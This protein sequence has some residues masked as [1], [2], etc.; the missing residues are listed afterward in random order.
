M[1]ADDLSGAADASVHFAGRRQVR[2]TYPRGPLWDARLGPE[3]V[4]VRDTETRS[5]A[6]SEAAKIVGECCQAL[7]TTF[8]E[9]AAVF[10]KIDSTL[11]GSLEGELLAARDALDR[12]LV[13]LAPSLPA[14]GRTV[15]RGRLVVEGVD[16]G[17]V[18]E[19]AAVVSL[20]TLRGGKD[21]LA[22]QSAPLVVIDAVTDA[23]L[24]LIAG[25]VAS[26]YD[27]L[28]AGSAGL[29]GALARSEG[30]SVPLP[31]QP[32]RPG[33]VVAVGSRHRLVR[34]HVGTLREANLTGVVLHDLLDQPEGDS[35]GIAFGLAKQAV[36]SLRA[37]PAGTA[38]IATGGDIALAICREL[39]AA[40]LCPQGELLPGVIWNLVEGPDL[41]LVT[42][43]GGFG[44][45]D[46]LL[47][48][49]LK[50]LGM[51]SGG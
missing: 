51:E 38:L 29:A 31:R 9:G 24:D 39:D 40:A 48:A 7:R 25:Q 47:R 34:S 10:K 43:A 23:D 17:P 20:E 14:Q 28:P 12:R 16:Q 21:A 13:V 49:A 18:L 50:L 36:L 2:I 27:V 44:D 8:G 41:V 35:T 15:E 30:P 26:H 32:P 33:V 19:G 4:Q 6:D 45:A 37:L 5:L 3:V 11:R 46:V 1:I 22:G 42:K